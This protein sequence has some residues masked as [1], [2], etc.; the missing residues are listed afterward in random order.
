MTATPIADWALPRRVVT[1]A[2]VVSLVLIAPVVVVFL[3]IGPAAA[4]SLVMGY[5]ASLVPALK[6][7]ARYALAL[8]VPAAMAGV[9]AAALNA[10]ALP[11]ACFVALVCLLAAPANVVQDKLVAGIPTVAAVF[12]TLPIRLEPMQ[13]GAWMLVGGVIAVAVASRLRRPAPPQGIPERTAWIHAVTMAVLVGATILV[14]ESLNVPHGYWAA[15]TLTV[16]LRPYGAET[17]MLARQRVLGTVAGALLALGLVL[18]LPAWALLAAT[19]VMV[20]LMV[21]YASVGN[22]AAQVTFMTPLIVLLGSAG[23]QPIPIAAD[24][25]LATGAGAALAIGAALALARHERGAGR[26]TA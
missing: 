25:I 3:V 9:V 12:A 26:V 8:A 6:V 10:T 7:K 11:A 4:L 23:G 19:A 18:V 14:V 20:V 24:R 2:A 17:Q 21:T 15:M 16:V 1:I 5:T 13:V 22:Y